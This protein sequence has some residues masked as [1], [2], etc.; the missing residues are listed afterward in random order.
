MFSKTHIPTH[1]WNASRSPS[2]NVI[3]VDISTPL[4]P[5]RVIRVPMLQSGNDLLPEVVNITLSNTHWAT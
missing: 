5:P 1:S 3:V 2:V 4:I